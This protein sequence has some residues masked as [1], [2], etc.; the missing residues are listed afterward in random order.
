M[1]TGSRGETLSPAI[2][3]ASLG[4][5]ERIDATRGWAGIAFSRFEKRERRSKEG[6]CKG[7]RGWGGLCVGGRAPS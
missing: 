4:Q 2:W 1:G 6:G 5:L 3:G 7:R